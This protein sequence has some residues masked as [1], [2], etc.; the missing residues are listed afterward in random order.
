MSNEFP[1]I[2]P[3]NRIAAR[4]IVTRCGVPFE[5]A[6]TMSLKELQ[7]QI[8]NFVQ[9][10]SI[11]ADEARKLLA[12]STQDLNKAEGKPLNAGA[13][14][15]QKEDIELIEAFCMG[16]TVEQLAMKHGRTNM[17]ITA[18]LQK[19]KLLD[20]SGAKNLERV[21]QLRSN[22]EDARARGDSLNL[23]KIERQ[24]QR[25]QG[26]SQ[27][28]MR[29][30][31]QQIM[32]Q[33]PSDEELKKILDGKELKFEIVQI[34]ERRAAALDEFKDLDEAE[35]SQG[36]TAEQAQAVPP[37]ADS[38]PPQI[39]M[40][41]LRAMIAE[42]VAE[43][44]KKAAQ[45][46]MKFEIKKPDGSSIKSEGLTHYAFP[47]L[48]RAVSARTRHDGNAL[49][50]WLYGPAGTGKST[51][52]RKLAEALNATFYTNGPVGSQWDI[53]GFT[54]AQGRV[55][56][57]QFREA[58]ING[59]VY[60]WDEGDGSA[61]AAL[62][63]AN[64]A[65]ATGFASFPDGVHRRHKECI[66]I[67][68]GNLR[69]GAAPDATYN[70]R[71]KQDTAFVNRFVAIDW[72]IDENLE[73]AL[74]GDLSG[75]HQRF[76]DFVMHVRGQ[77][78]ARAIKG[79]VV[80]PRQLQYGMALLDQGADFDETRNNVVK[81]MFTDEQWSQVCEGFSKGKSKGKPNKAETFAAQY[82]TGRYEKSS[83]RRRYG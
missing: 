66:V 51:A 73:R 15:A 20:M 52:A 2:T 19:H 6:R 29:M 33:L 76:Y 4:K 3:V 23:A 11:T 68:N 14:W 48:L 55:V 9:I 53:R 77:V 27:A 8:E 70:G 30:Q 39:D 31:M 78:K 24:A 50:I 10:K 56:S 47:Q 82:Q 74:L 57:T 58:W 80:S 13:P 60:C 49:N 32:Q 61:P 75:D 7:Q 5:R 71:F 21:R 38:I 67:I 25:Q 54:D 64:G 81:F 37:P 12:T 16:Q 44:V 72:G 36:D 40:E 42:Q 26:F 17:G 63:E 18:R 28:E 41:A 43:Q 1:S 69:P 62:I 34:D 79:V 59:G 22:M 35:K 65:L 46:V 45:S 83:G